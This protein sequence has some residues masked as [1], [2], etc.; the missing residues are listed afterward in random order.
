MKKTLL[1]LFSLLISFCATAQSSQRQKM[2][3]M[4]AVRIAEQ[5]EVPEQN[6]EAFITL[7]QKYKGESSEIVKVRPRDGEDPEKT[8]E[9]KIL[10]DFEKSR[11]ILSLREAYYFKFREVLTP[12]QIQKMYDLERVAKDAPP[13]QKQ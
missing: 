7:Y 12:S 9:L 8:V 5:I 2:I 3:H 6:R 11:K 13:R 10:D 4:A 1:I